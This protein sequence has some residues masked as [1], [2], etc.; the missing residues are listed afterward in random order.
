MKKQQKVSPTL[1]RY[2]T[3]GVTPNK[4]KQADAVEKLK[5]FIIISKMKIDSILE[6]NATKTYPKLVSNS[7]ANQQMIDAIK[8]LLKENLQEK[9]NFEVNNLKSFINSCQYILDIISDDPKVSVDVLNFL[10]NL[11]ATMRN[12]KDYSRLKFERKALVNKV[13]RYINNT[14]SITRLDYLK[15]LLL[16]ANQ[17]FNEEYSYAPPHEIDHILDDYIRNNRSKDL[18]RSLATFV[19]YGEPD[20]GFFNTIMQFVN[21]LIDDFGI[22]TNNAQVIIFTSCIRFLFNESYSIRSI[23]NEYREENSAFL[24]KCDLYSQQPASSL[25]LSK[26]IEKYYVPGLRISSLFKFKQVSMLKEMDYITNPIDMMAQIFF[27]ID[28]LAQYFGSEVGV[29]AFDDTLTLFLA[30]M[31]MSPPSNCISIVKFINKWS[32]LQSSRVFKDATNFFLIAVE[33][34]SR[35]EIPKSEEITSVQIFKNGE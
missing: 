13:S 18:I 21:E 35:I 29:L 11:N 22:T 14:V 27:I 8:A 10:N 6:K 17:K 16:E 9:T 30:L 7:P 19:A 32:E 34:I 26:D 5:N 23:L 28:S 2:L 25:K 15:N 20:D 24:I 4:K 1:Q 33:Q 12:K 3:F 31:S